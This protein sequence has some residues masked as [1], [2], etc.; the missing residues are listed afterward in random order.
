MVRLLYLLAG[1]KYSIIQQCGHLVKQKYRNVGVAQVLA[2]IIA[3]V[4]AYDVAHN[5]TESKVALITA[6][7]GWALCIGLFDFF[8]ITSPKKHWTLDLLRY[9]VALANQL[10]SIAAIFVLLTGA[11][12]QNKINADRSLRSKNVDVAY[13]NAMENRWKEYKDLENEKNEY[14]KRECMAQAKNGFPGPL[15]DRLHTACIQNDAS[16]KTMKSILDVAET[17][18]KKAYDDERTSIQSESSNDFF[19]KIQY[20][21]DVLFNNWAKGMFAGCFFIMFFYLETIAISTKSNIDPSDEYHQKLAD[22]EKQQDEIQMTK[23]EEEKIKEA[24]KLEIDGKQAAAKHAQ[25][26]YEFY[27]ELGKQVFLNETDYKLFNNLVETYGFTQTKPVL[28]K[29]AE[30][31]RKMQGLQQGQNFE[32]FETIDIPTN[33]EPIK[34]PY[35]PKAEGVFKINQAIID[36]CEN[37]KNDAK[38]PHEITNR[39][40]T[41]VH[42]NITYDDVHTGDFYRTALESF[43]ARRSICGEMSV[44]IMAMLKYFGIECHYLRVTVDNMGEECSHACVGIVNEGKL[45][46]IDAAFHEFDL[47]PQHQVY[48]FVGDAVLEERFKKWNSY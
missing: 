46:M 22:D 41:W 17:P 9:V 45:Q 26:L 29:M 39:I 2:M 32:S 10:I 18:Y 3:S 16:L 25:K 38:T 12:L 7:L 4:A 35:K 6:S 31:L 19:I 24:N 20:L 1:V 44:L 27:Q 23:K 30:A 11:S 15:Y 21:P 8:L 47:Q 5:F 33:D 14:H 13:Q 43:R 48:E 42:E 28:E 37:F 40:Y 36:L 34:N